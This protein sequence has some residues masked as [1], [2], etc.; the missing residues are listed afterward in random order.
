MAN[1]CMYCGAPIAPADSFCMACGAPV[2]RES[3]PPVSPPVFPADPVGFN[4]LGYPPPEDVDGAHVDVNAS[5]KRM[6]TGEVFPVDTTPFVIGRRKSQVNLY[7]TDSPSVSREHASIEYVGGAFSV[8]DQGSANKTY[9]NDKELEPFKKIPLTSG[10]VLKLG[11]EK[12]VF[13]VF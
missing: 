1:F 5:L 7:V 2:E 12:F 13:L 6:K 3:E 4:D 9:L 11:D 8:R 10:D